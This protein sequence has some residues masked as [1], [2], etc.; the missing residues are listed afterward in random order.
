MRKRRP[1]RTIAFNGSRRRS[2]R[3]AKAELNGVARF[4]AEVASQSTL[5]DGVWGV[6]MRDDTLISR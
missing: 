3:L 1:W 2:C 5:S 4:E 6:T